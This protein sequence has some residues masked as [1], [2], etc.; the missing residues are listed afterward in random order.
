MKVCLLVWEL[1]C[2]HE[3]VAGVAHRSLEEQGPFNVI[4]HKLV[5]RDPFYDELESYVRMHPHTRVI[6]EVKRVRSLQTR[7]GP[8]IPS[9]AV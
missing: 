9:S 1:R 4:I 3:S 2:V 8:H 5:P 7:Y 6:D